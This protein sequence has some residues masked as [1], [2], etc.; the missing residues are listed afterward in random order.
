[1]DLLN[2]YIM[3]GNT[4]VAEVENNN[5]TITNKD[6]IPLYLKYKNDVIGWLDRRSIDK[7]RTHSRMIKKLLRITDADDYKVALKVHACSV[8]DNYWFKYTDESISYENVKFKKPFLDRMA[9]L[10][11]RDSFF[12]G[13]YES[14]T[15]SPELTNIGSY[16]KCWTIENNSWFLH[17]VGNIDEQYAECF[18]EKICNALNIPAAEYYITEKGIKTKDF[19]E[20]GKYNFES[21]SFLNS[22]SIGDYKYV[23]SSLKQ[24]NPSLA[25]QYADLMYIDALCFNTDRHE[26]N[27]G[28]LRDSTSGDIVSLAPN[29]DNN[30]ALLTNIN[31]YSNL[32]NKDILL[33][34]TI[35]LFNEFKI[36]KPR[37]LTEKEVSDIATSICDYDKV[38]QVIDIILNR[39]KILDLSI[40]NY[41]E[42]SEPEIE[43]DD[44]IDL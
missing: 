3:S 44:D 24:L 35:E 5:I 7:H 36:C 21:V 33:L 20:N 11:E 32:K 43:T 2:G 9:L 1:M 18:V 8:I 31:D 29:F 40:N 38:E 14:N 42:I 15:P 12:N 28:L 37:L 27:F 39:Q 10:G 17:K 13:D 26:E 22:E 6:L 41:C 25:K 4:I 16:E 30:M 19:T 34:D 23:Y